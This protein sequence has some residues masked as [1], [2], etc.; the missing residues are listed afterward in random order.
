MHAARGTDDDYGGFYDHVERPAAPH[1][2]SPCNVWNAQHNVSRTAPT[3]C[4]AP[5][6]FQRLGL[7][8]STMLIS[9]WVA[10]ASV[11]NEPTRRA[12]GMVDVGSAPPPQWDHTSML[13]TAK[14]LFGLPHF[15][16]K[17]DAWAGAFDELLLD[18]PRPDADCP[19]HLP[20]PPAPAHPWPT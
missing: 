8:S 16:T 18:E 11:I 1:D 6:D 19:M 12:D 17:R 9:P 5:F 2:E 10:K 14:N 13:A 7:R 4:P 20:D 15:L 3:V